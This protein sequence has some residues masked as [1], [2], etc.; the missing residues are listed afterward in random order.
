MKRVKLKAFTAIATSLTLLSSPAMA[1]SHREAPAIT[2]RPKVDGTDF[3]MFRSYEPGREGFVTIIANY[4]PL[5][6]PYGGPNYFT[7]DPNALYEIHIDSDGDAN[8]DLTFSF[9]FANSLRNNNGIV[10][11]IGG[12]P[13]PIAI[14]AIGP[15]GSAS[16][17]NLGET[18]Q[19]T[20]TLTRGDRRTGAKSVLGT[21]AKPLDN[22][23]TKTIPNYAAYAGQ[24]VFP[25]NIPG[26]AGGGRVFAGQRAEAFAVNLG[27]VFD[28][29]N[30][31][32]IDGDRVP[33]SNDGQGFPGG[34]RQ[35]RENDD[36]VGEKNITSLAIE[37]PIACLTGN[38]NGVIGGWTTAS[39][40]QGEALDPTP[41]FASPSTV[42]GAF[43]QVS[44]LSHPLINELVIGVPFKDLFNAAEPIGDAQV[45]DFVTNP[46]FPAILNTLFRAPVNAGLGANLADLAPNNFPRADLVATF[47]T[48]IRTLNQ[49]ATVRGAEIMRL[50]TA[51]SPT[52]RDRQSTFGVVGDDLA[53][54]PNGRRPGDDA[55]DITLRVAMGRLC[56]PVPINGASTDLGI[57]TPASAPTGLVAYTDGAPIS[58]RELGNAF[59]YLTTPIPGAPL[60]ARDA[61]RTSMVPQ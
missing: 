28:L 53:G 30:F 54:Y 14:R 10:L 18:E 59:P 52:P 12:K 38:G 55:V 56:H 5:Q 19:Y 29:V 42:G 27:P 34:I 11:N 51:I 21:F 47:L 43:T 36:V 49:Q 1:S 17:P 32:P 33:G 44:R 6:D 60:S 61:R 31:V 4:Q 39:L 7:M 16:D 58:A 35:S 9:A 24:F 22:I 2:K 13:L 57:C 3:Y 41:T 40:P 25:L 15:V 8:E 45:L 50:N 20:V 23:G 48:G 37:V 46:T 26:C